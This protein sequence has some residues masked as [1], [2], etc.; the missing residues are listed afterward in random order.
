MHVDANVWNL[1]CAEN[2]HRQ[3]AGA[4]MQRL[5]GKILLLG[6]KGRR[7]IAVKLEERRR[8][9]SLLPPPSPSFPFSSSSSSSR[10]PSPLEHAPRA[11][12]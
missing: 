12:L 4:A 8:C 10:P 11:R 1:L 5:F 6:W 2:V 7:W 3:P 9:A